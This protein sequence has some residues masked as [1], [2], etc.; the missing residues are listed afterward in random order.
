MFARLGFEHWLMFLLWLDR[1]P[2][3][4]LETDQRLVH[5]CEIQARYIRKSQHAE[6]DDVAERVL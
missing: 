2:R 6:D 1:R 4:G 3:Q 5:P